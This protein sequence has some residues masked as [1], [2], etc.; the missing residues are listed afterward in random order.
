MNRPIFLVVAIFLLLGVGGTIAWRMIRDN[1]PTIDVS[2]IPTLSKPVDDKYLPLDDR[3]HLWDIE[4]LALVIEQKVFPIW[5]KSIAE[6]KWEPLQIQFGEAFRSTPYLPAN[7]EEVLESGIRFVSSVSKHLGMEP[8]IALDFSQN[9]EISDTFLQELISLR[10]QFG[11][12]KNDCKVS[13]GIL[14]LTPDDETNLKGS[15]T[16]IWKLKLKGHHKEHSLEKTLNIKLS[17][18]E[19]NDEI[20]SKTGWITAGSIL[21]SK[22][23]SGQTQLFLDRTKE[24]GIPVEK[25][26][27]NWNCSQFRPNTGGVYLND[28]DQ[29]GILDLLVDDVQYGF[30]LYHGEGK[31]KYRDVTVSS[32]LQQSESQEEPLW[33]LSC[34]GDFDN[35]GDSDLIA[36]T[37]LFENMGDGTFREITEQSNLPL[38]PASGYAVA[39]YNN[40][41]LL[42]L[43]AC[44]GGSYR[45]GQ[46]QK[47]KIPWIDG[48][49]GIDNVLWKNLGNWQFE[50][51]TEETNT[52][53][54]GSSCFTAVWFDANNDRKPDL[55]AIN[56]FGRN[57]LLIQ[58]QDGTF[59][60][61]DVD[62]VY[63]GLSMGVTCGDYD[64][65]GLTDIYVANMYSKA[66][67]RILANVNP[68]LYGEKLHQQI[69]EATVGN[70][71]YRSRGDGTFEVLPPD[72]IVAQVG[73]AYGPNFADFDQDGDLDLYATAGFK[74]NVRGKPDG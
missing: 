2:T 31:G 48:G 22:E 3:Q 51:V 26:Y 18:R 55:L 15:W 62:P 20:S 67:S 69:T 49:L 57:S 5:K 64:N 9:E 37:H 70:K 45:P 68:S 23:V 54:S 7:E 25:L 12:E 8:P 71:L 53:G 35:D 11:N 27:D 13:L 66:G 60:E 63:G 50:D 4:H 16:T 59:V 42:D 34:W 38:V 29:D 32:G 41:G 56:E 6:R 36:E 30:R 40:D 28:Y 61:S 44:H 43:Y 1:T 52:G 24:T 72:Q 21:K 47:S 65:D 14:R 17:L 39:D 10:D 58:Q 73:W 19:L 46:K 33:T 74:S